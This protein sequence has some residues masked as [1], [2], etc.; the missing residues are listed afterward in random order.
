[1]AAVPHAVVAGAVELA[2]TDGG[3]AGE[4][5]DPQA[6]AAYRHRLED[7]ESEIEDAESGDDEHRAGQ[8]RAERDMLAAELARGVG[9]GGR[10]RKAAS[11]AERA[12]LNVTRAIGA[13][14]RKIV[15]QDR[16]LGRHLETSVHTGV[17]CSYT[18]HETIAW[19]L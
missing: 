2:P 5:L 11:H 6:R 14:L 4:L 17:F 3:D 19:E 16:I 10:S 15:A 13:V 8:L 7:L 12:R 9:L 18:P 1:A